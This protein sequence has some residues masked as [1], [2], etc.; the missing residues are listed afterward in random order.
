MPRWNTSVLIML[1]MVHRF[2][3]R[4]W[5]SFTSTTRCPAWRLEAQVEIDR[6]VAYRDDDR[7]RW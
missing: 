5:S 4:A 3:W 7:N 6:V 1:V 2:M